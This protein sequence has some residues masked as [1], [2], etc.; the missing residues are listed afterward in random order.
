MTSLISGFLFISG[1]LLAQGG[2]VSYKVM[3]NTNDIKNLE[4]KMG[5]KFVMNAKEI[6]NLEIKMG[7]KFVMNAKEIQ[8]L[9][10]KMDEKFVMNAKENSKE[11]RDLERAIVS[12]IFNLQSSMM[13][14]LSS[15]PNRR[16]D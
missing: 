12:Q 8:N 13:T 10:T 3:E 5:E 4:T 16:P 1:G 14:V 15:P 9:E 11:I 7:E 2:F 6:Q